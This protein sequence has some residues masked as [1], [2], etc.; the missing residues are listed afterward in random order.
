[1]APQQQQGFVSS[2]VHQLYI[3]RRPDHFIAFVRTRI[4]THRVVVVHTEDSRHPYTEPFYEE[5][6]TI[7]SDLPSDLLLKGHR[8][9]SVDQTNELRG[10][11]TMVWPTLLVGDES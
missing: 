2:L 11:N 8:K 9:D 6:T 1:M 7:L 3:N 10:F 5:Q 4:S